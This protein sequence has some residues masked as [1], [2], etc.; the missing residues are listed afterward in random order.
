[1]INI[2][3]YCFVLHEESVSLA[4]QCFVCWLEGR[5]PVCLSRWGGCHWWNSDDPWPLQRLGLDQSTAG[6]V[7]TLEDRQLS[8][9]FRI[10]SPHERNQSNVIWNDS[11]HSHSCGLLLCVSP[12]EQVCVLRRSTFAENQ[13]QSTSSES[14]CTPPERRWRWGSDRLHSRIRRLL[15]GSRDITAS[16]ALLWQVHT[17]QRLT[18]FTILD[19]AVESLDNL[20]PGDCIVCF[21]KNDI[22][23]ISRQIEARGLECA[24]IYGSLPPGECTHPW[25]ICTF[26]LPQRRN[27]DKS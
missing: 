16:S 3:P 2:D 9:L 15:S 14:W 22:Y 24:V 5:F 27:G 1:M 26:A 6:S 12:C 11:P 19:Q 18:P 10:L 20:R 25:R 23:S 13:Q 8:T 4:E 7:N 21:S 17:Y